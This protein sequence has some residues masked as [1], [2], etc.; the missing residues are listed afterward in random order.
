MEY[1]LKKPCATCM[2]AEGMPDFGPGD[3][4]Q[5]RN[6]PRIKGRVLFMG[7]NENGLWMIYCR[8]YG[9]D[10]A[11]QWEKVPT[12]KTVT[13]R[14]AGPPDV[15]DKFLAAARPVPDGVRVERVEDDE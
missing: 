5:K 13:L 1:K 6:D 12:E 4:V 14:Y 2:S 8:S 10:T 15:I 7:Q 9:V 3:R 11:S